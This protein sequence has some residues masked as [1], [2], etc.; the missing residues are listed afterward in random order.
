MNGKNPMQN[1]MMDYSIHKV[2]LLNYIVPKS[3]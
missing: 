2:T 1:M 3:F